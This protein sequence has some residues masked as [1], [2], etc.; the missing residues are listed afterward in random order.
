MISFMALALYLTVLI[1]V[2]HQ[3]V[4]QVD[5][6]PMALIE[7]I[8][9]VTIVAGI[10]AMLGVLNGMNLVKNRDGKEKSREGNKV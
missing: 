2:M 7:A 6:G 8:V 10:P 4:V 9:L 5:N 3:S 1:V